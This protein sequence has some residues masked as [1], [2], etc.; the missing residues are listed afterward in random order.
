MNLHE[1][2]CGDDVNFSLEDDESMAFLFVW[3][4]HALVAVEL[5]SASSG[6]RW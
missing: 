4:F 3:A 2:K 5:R 6:K 1:I